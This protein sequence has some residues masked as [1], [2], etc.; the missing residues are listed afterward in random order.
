M[1]LCF[2]RAF[3]SLRAV[4]FSNENRV[5]KFA[6]WFFYIAGIYGLIVL[7][8][9]YFMESQIARDSTPVA[10]PEFFYGFLGV[11]VAWQVAF[12]VIGR[13]PIRYRLLMI[14]SILEKVSFAGATAVLFAQERIAVNML[15]AGMADLTW[16]VLFAVAMWLTRPRGTA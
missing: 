12:L 1:Q 7:L 5:M 8:P 14:P 4:L 2:L 9:M 11:A 15:A 16:A 3:A 13:D 10:H 6:K